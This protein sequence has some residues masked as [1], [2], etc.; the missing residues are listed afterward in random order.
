[1]VVNGVCYFCCCGDLLVSLSLSLSLSVCVCVCLCV[2]VRVCVCVCICVSVCPSVSRVREW[3][4]FTHWT[5]DVT[6]TFPIQT[7]PTY[8][9]IINY[10][11]FLPRPGSRKKRRK[12]TCFA[13]LTIPGA[14]TPAGWYTTHRCNPFIS[15]ATPTNHTPSVMNIS[16]NSH[17]LKLTIWTSSRVIMTPAEMSAN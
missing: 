14:A 9:Q 13:K 17:V 2:C 11:H 8:K 5:A 12:K 10:Q 15:S 4:P 16:S 6:C 1:M 7:V 3:V